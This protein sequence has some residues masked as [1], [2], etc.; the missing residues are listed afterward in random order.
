MYLTG[1]T[2]FD[3]AQGASRFIEPVEMYLT[4]TALFEKAQ[5]AN[6][7]A[8]SDRLRELLVCPSKKL[9]ELNPLAKRKGKQNSNTSTK[10]MPFP[11]HD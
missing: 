10:P 11:L 3:K 4:S 8:P 2:P 6:N 5:G 1:T 7:T 9:R